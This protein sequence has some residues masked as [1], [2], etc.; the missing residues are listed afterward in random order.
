MDE[1]MEGKKRWAEEK[2]EGGSERT[3]EQFVVRRA[4][5]SSQI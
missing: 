4:L 5:Y 3:K 1:M 2:K